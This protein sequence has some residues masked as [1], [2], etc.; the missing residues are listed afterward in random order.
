[1]ASLESCDM[2]SA[3]FTQ[4]SQP[5]RFLAYQKVQSSVRRLSISRRVLEWVQWYFGL[6]IHQLKKLSGT[7]RSSL[8]SETM[9]GFERM[10]SIVPRLP[11]SYSIKIASIFRLS[12][13]ECES[14]HCPIP[15]R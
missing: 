1:M 3:K 14:K 9:Q 10:Y 11:F 2:R 13:L 15:D 8:S 6:K 7:R 5:K 12:V 4:G